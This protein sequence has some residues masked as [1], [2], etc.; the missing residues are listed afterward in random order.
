MSRGSARV[1]GQRRGYRLKIDFWPIGILNG[2]MTHANTDDLFISTSH[3]ATLRAETARICSLHVLPEIGGIIWAYGRPTGFLM[4]MEAASQA[5]AAGMIIRIETTTIDYWGLESSAHDPSQAIIK[6]FDRTFA[7]PYVQEPA[8]SA[9]ASYSDVWDFICG[10]APTWSIIPARRWARSP[11]ESAPDAAL[12]E[13][14]RT[15]IR[16]FAAVAHRPTA[17]MA[18]I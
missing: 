9:V 5:R 15:Y 12:R 10:D 7:Y 3:E 18:Q 4:F 1:S 16:W 13:G 14:L 6:L 17:P 11:D 2:S 8:A